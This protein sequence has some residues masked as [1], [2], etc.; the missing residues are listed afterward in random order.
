ML[1]V[2]WDGL[3]AV[4]TLWQSLLSRQ[5]TP[6]KTCCPAILERMICHAA[7]VRACVSVGEASGFPVTSK[8]VL[9]QSSCTFSSGEYRKR[10]V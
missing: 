9:T 6:V 10:W 1:P 5:M 7:N 8:L 4:T 3:G 2:Q